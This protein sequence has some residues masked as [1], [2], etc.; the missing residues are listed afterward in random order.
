MY[1]Y[2]Y[3]HI[4]IFLIDVARFPKIIP[5]NSHILPPE[6]ARSCSPWPSSSS[7]VSQGQES[8]GLPSNT[9]FD[10]EPCEPKK[11]EI[12]WLCFVS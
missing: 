12:M 4:H 6:A 10:C 11:G 3:I 9:V 1:V 7:L 5:P 8:G 2:I